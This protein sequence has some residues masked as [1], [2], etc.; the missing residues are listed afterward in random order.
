MNLKTLIDLKVDS[1]LRSPHVFQKF[2][3]LLVSLFYLFAAG[4]MLLLLSLKIKLL[5]GFIGLSCSDSFSF[6]LTVVLLLASI[7]FFLKVLLLK[8]RFSF[9]RLSYLPN[10]SKALK[11]YYYIKQLI[12]VVLFYISFL[13]SYHIVT[14]IVPEYGMF[15]AS[16]CIVFTYSIS[17]FN[18]QLVFYFK[19]RGILLST[20]IASSILVCGVV[21]MLLY[22]SRIP[23]IPQALP[24]LSIL[25]ILVSI[26]LFPINYRAV[27]YSLDQNNQNKELRFSSVGFGKNRIRLYAILFIK[28]TIRSPM[29]RKQVLMMTALSFVYILMIKPVSDP[30]AGTFMIE[31]IW[32]LFIFLFVPLTISQQSFR[33]EGSFFDQLYMTPDMQNLL[34]ARYVVG[35]LFSIVM[36][37]FYCGIYTVRFGHMPAWNMFVPAWLLGIGPFLLLSFLSI[38][39]TGPKFEL[40]DSS[41]TASSQNNSKIQ[42][43]FVM[44]LITLTLCL[45]YVLF[46]YTSHSIALWAMAIVGGLSVLFSFKYLDFIFKLYH[47]RR[48]KRMESY[49]VK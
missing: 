11:Q 22:F 16:M 9:A 33:A 29:L 27:C 14:S 21:Y 12:S 43:L 25:L 2:L 41:W 7:D 26:I 36:I 8:N 6:Y 24:G 28:M 5:L 46:E 23:S 18:S 4:S 20:L 40:F 32:P 48:Y 47:Q 15:T 38:F 19:Q 17:L 45:C 34:K 3:L 10:T 31:V 13:L 30:T 35:I 49:R 44:V 1:V 42:S 37:L 39:I